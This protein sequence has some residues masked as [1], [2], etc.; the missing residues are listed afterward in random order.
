MSEIIPSEKRNNLT[1]YIII[2]LILGIGSG[3]WLNNNYVAKENA[4]IAA[5]NDSTR[6]LREEMNIGDYSIDGYIKEKKKIQDLVDRQKE[7]TIARDKK[8]EPFSLMGDLFLRLIKMIIAPLVFSTLVV[9]VAKL[10]DI[11]SVG[12]IGAKTLA[13]FLS[14]SCLSLFLGI[15]LVNFFKPG[16]AMHLPVPDTAD[17]GIGTAAFTLKDFLY[18][19]FPVSVV[20]AMAKNEILQIVVFSILFGVATAAI[21]EKG[22]IIKIKSFFWGEKQFFIRN[23]KN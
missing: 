9:G 7:A 11:K 6:I 13:W 8:L 12:R 4:I 10:G 20:D 15:V 14:A 18:H 3:F 17:T 2:S 22:K 1:L 5:S 16:I 21:V 23:A 19:V